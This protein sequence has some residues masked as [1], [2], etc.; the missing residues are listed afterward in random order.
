MTAHEN[1]AKFSQKFEKRVLETETIM[2]K[3]E[4]GGGLAPAEASLE[5]CRWHKSRISRIIV[6]FLLRN[7]YSRSAGLLLA[8]GDP[9]RTALGLAKER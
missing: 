2:E 3:Q 5:L 8:S 1:S 9:V 4:A 7:G 6:E